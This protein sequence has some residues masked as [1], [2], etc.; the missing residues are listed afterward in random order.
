V[1]GFEKETEKK[2][3]QFQEAEAEGTVPRTELTSRKSGTRSTK[4]LLD[5]LPTGPTG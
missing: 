2:K 1:S 3:G 5:L 4:S